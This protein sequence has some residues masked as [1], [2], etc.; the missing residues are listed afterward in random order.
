[1]LSHL[2]GSV[3][4]LTGEEMRKLRLRKGESHTKPVLSAT[5]TKPGMA[6]HIYSPSGG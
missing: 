6:V 5:D 1:M 3:F 4:A 2:T